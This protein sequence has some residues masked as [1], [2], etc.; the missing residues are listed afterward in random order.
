VKVGIGI[1]WQIVIDGQ[2]DTL[3]INTTTKNIS[4]NANTFV[5]LFE[6]LVT[7]DTFCTSVLSLR[8]R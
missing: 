8:V 1:R 4:R 3:N 7:L 2:V 5:E 6:F